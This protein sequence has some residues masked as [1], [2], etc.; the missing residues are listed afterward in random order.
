MHIVAALAALG[1]G[2]G[3]GVWKNVAA[4]PGGTAPQEKALTYLGGQPDL[5]ETSEAEA[6]SRLFGMV[7]FETFADAEDRLEELLEDYRRLAPNRSYSKPLEGERILAEIESILALAGESEIVAFLDGKVFDH[8][9]MSLAD[10]VYGALARFSPK[11]AADLWLSEQG[12]TGFFAGFH[13]VMHEWVRIDPVAAESWVSAIPEEKAK[14]FALHSMLSH[15]AALDP[16]S[17]ISRFEDID[18]EAGSGVAMVLG[19]T[20]ELAALSETADRFLEER[21]SGD[22]AAALLK[23]FLP[24]WGER[25]PE[26]MLAWVLVQDSEA[27]GADIL[28]EGLQ[29]FATKD[30]AGFLERISSHLGENPDLHAVAAQSWWTWLASE[31][32]EVTAIRWLGDHSE[33]SMGFGQSFM[34]DFYMNRGDW[35]QDKTN[36]LL[37]AFAELPDSPSKA[38]F[39][40][41]L[42]R[43]LS[44][45]NPEMILAYAMEHLP[46]GS[47]TDT[48]IADAVSNWATEAPEAALRWSL[49]NVKS[50]GARDRALRWAIARWGEKEGRVAADFAMNL[51][52]KERGIAMWELGFAWAAKEPEAVI[53]FLSKAS[54]PDAVSSMSRSAFR[55]FG[56]RQGAAEYFDKA[57]AMPPG[58]LR[59]DAVRGLFGGWAIS[60]LESAASAIHRVPAGTLRDASI[61]GFNTYAAGSNPKKAMEFAEEITVPATREKELILRARAWL[62]QN[63]AEAEAAI[64]AHPSLSEAMKAEIY[65]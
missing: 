37:A 7:S 34:F 12:K 29:A 35:S 9:H 20:L 14:K 52:D 61:Q 58:R 8:E 63:R 40:E 2:F 27:I 56:E 62:K 3:A 19:A 11:R 42:F 17:V 38:S 53:G 32:G 59:H 49:E 21:E 64:R 26:A 46:L 54:D 18:P 50:E 51:P 30:P 16:R 25:D 13:P 48:V 55:Q 15:L 10:I 23:S 31:G 47:Q 43:G 39:T 44:R 33:L 45:K 1:I 6:F 57:L 41:R 24:E 28:R 60:D 36:R 65:K 5:T 22:D 4:D